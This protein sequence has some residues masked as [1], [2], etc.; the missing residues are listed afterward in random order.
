M[1][2]TAIKQSNGIFIPFENIKEELSQNFTHLILEIEIIEY[3]N[4]I[5]KKT[6]GILKN[7]NIDGLEYEKKLRKEWK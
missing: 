3:K 4:D 7:F 5:I 2:V 1:L 6:A